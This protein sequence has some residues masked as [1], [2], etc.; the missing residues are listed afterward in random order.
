MADYIMAEKNNRM[1]PEEDKIFALN[2][3]A[4]KMSEEAGRDKVINATIGSL[5]DDDGKLVMLLSVV[6]ALKELEP[7]DFAEYAPIGGTPD[8]KKAVTKAA[9]GK[10]R[11]SSFVEV[12]ATPGG[13]GALRNIVANYSKIGDRVMTSDWFWG[14][15]KTITGELYRELCVYP[16]F[17]EKNRFNK[18]GFS[19]ELNKLAADQESVL[20]LLN[21]PSHNPTGYSLDG[22]DWNGISEAVKEAS[23]KARITLFVDAAY[24][25]FAGDEEE[26]RTFLP[27]LE[28]MPS[29]VLPVIGY[30]FSKTFTL[31]GMRCGAMIA[32]AP[33]EEIAAEFKLV[34]EFSARG[35]W[36]NSTRSGQV[37]VSKVYEDE[38]LLESVNKERAGYR[39]MLIK[40]GKA[41]SNSVIEAGLPLVPFDS[42]FFSCIPLKDP[43]A[44]SKRLEE[45]GIFVV[46]LA[47]GIRVSVASISE[48]ICRKLPGMIAEAIE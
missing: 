3:R 40:R 47:K 14:P 37:L 2:A 23:K 13:T 5:L 39:E 18:K 42:G 6:K 12:V 24:I 11:S 38:D 10:H 34:N 36:S 45:K 32:M 7:L 30:S 22:D 9:F 20:I 19:E 8:F 16:M 48:E 41:F 15:Y 1:I 29:N 4:K 26:Y 17:D 44:V 46:P 33:S 25:D 43:V 28:D 35:T 21:T 27:K 31:Y